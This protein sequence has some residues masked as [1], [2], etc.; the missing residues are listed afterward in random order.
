MLQEAYNEIDQGDFE[1]RAVIL[2][3]RALVERESKRLNEALRLHDE[4]KPLFENINN[5]LLTAHYHHAYAN[6]LNRLSAGEE[7]ENYIDLALIEYTAASFHF[8]EAG[9]ERYQ[10]YVENNLGYLLGKVGRFRDAHEHL[11][12]AQALMTRLK[13]NV[14]LGQVDETRATLLLAENRNIEGEK[15]AR[16]AVV[17]LEKG[18]ERS[19][20]V[21][22]LTTHGISLARLAHPDSAREAMRKKGAPARTLRN[23]R[24]G[25]AII[26]FGPD[27]FDPAYLDEA[28]PHEFIHV[29]GQD[30]QYSWGGWLFGGHDLSGFNQKA[31]EDIMANCKDH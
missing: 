26:F 8:G 23:N 7:R 18:D 1:Q 9:H 31:Y 19:L 10:A 13:D 12:R 4:A 21:E 17:R 15:V 29:G 2:M 6:V 5:H 30:A 16:A 22:A 25:K 20:L 11:D 3:R 28:V 14:H 24:T 27:A